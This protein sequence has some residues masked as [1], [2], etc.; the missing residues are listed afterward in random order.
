MSD[1]SNASIVPNLNFDGLNAYEAS[2]AYTAFHHPSDSG[3]S[4]TDG[5]ADEHG[6]AAEA[7]VDLMEDVRLALERVPTDNVPES[8]KKVYPYVRIFAW[9]S[10]LLAGLALAALIFI[11]V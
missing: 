9:T 3:A 1:H 2:S 11:F 5:W 10:I 6:D 4:G 8:Q 7:Q